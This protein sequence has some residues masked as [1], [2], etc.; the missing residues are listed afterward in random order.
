[1]RNI[2]YIDCNYIIFHLYGLSVVILWEL[3]FLHVLLFI[4][5]GFHV[6]FKPASLWE[7]FCTLITII[8][9]FICMF[10][11]KLLYCEKYFVHWLQLYN[12]SSLWVLVNHEFLQPVI[13]CDR[14]LHLLFF[15]FI[16]NFMCSL[17]LP[18]CE[19]YFSHWLQLYVWVIMLLACGT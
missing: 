8:K 12:F 7:I 18:V 11:F 5:M 19:K 14:F 9:K 3:I 4:C 6:L 1:M 17:K 2:Y 16:W 15:F 10:F 13:F